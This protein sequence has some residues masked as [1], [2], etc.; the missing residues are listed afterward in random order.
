MKKRSIILPAIAWLVILTSAGALT[1]A[2]TEQ[3]DPQSKQWNMRMRD[4]WMKWWMMWWLQWMKNLSETDR[5]ALMDLTQK[6]IDSKDFTAFKAAHTKYWITVNMTQDQFNTMLTKKAEMDTKRAEKEALK[7]EVQESI[8]NWDFATRKTLNA[9]KPILKY[10]DTEAKFTKLQ[11]MESYREKIQTIVKD[12]WLPQWKWMW[13]GEWMG[14]W[15]W[16]WMGFG[17]DN[18]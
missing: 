7:I 12:L 4:W 16:R 14:M 5:Q 17:W 18:K 8:K 6:A 13:E 1:F 10:I 15:W 2:S 9:D 3:S 11:E